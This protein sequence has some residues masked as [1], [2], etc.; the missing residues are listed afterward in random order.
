[1]TASCGIPGLFNPAVFDASE[2]LIIHNALLAQVDD[3][4]AGGVYNWTHV[5]LMSAERL[6]ERFTAGFD[7][8]SDIPTAS[9]RAVAYSLLVPV[10]DVDHPDLSPEEWE[11]AEAMLS[12]LAVEFGR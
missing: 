6:L 9:V 7:T 5:Q 1:M 3:V 10:H 8:I 12:F 11:V 2:R 4:H